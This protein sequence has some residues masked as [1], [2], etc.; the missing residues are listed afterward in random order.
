MRITRDCTGNVVRVQF[1][2]TLMCFCK[3]TTV[4]VSCFDYLTEPI[5]FLSQNLKGFVSMQYTTKEHGLFNRRRMS[6]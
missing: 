5:W 3:K 1:T 6:T 4:V 2:L